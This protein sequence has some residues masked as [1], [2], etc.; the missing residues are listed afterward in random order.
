MSTLSSPEE[1]PQS[2]ERLTEDISAF[3]R[4]KALQQPLMDYDHRL[5]KVQ[6]YDQLLAALEVYLED[7]LDLSEASPSPFDQFAEA[8]LLA[9][10]TWFA[11]SASRA[12]ADFRMLPLEYVSEMIKPKLS[13]KY[14]EIWLER[15]AK[16]AL[17]SGEGVQH[18]NCLKTEREDKICKLGDMCPKKRVRHFLMAPVSQTDFQSA[19]YKADPNK[20]DRDMMSRLRILRNV[21]IMN[22]SQH[23]SAQGAY[24]NR[25][26]R[27]LS[28]DS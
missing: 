22:D 24:Q 16:L 2:P 9:D 15:A 26:L 28:D 14:Y 18:T 20:W 6:E 8:G 19:E 25:R 1:V 13:E 11:F 10:E 4:I 12:V 3:E 21:N 23:R 7:E 27:A 5:R 17:V